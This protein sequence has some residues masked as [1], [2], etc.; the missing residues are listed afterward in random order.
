MVVLGLAYFFAGNL[1]NDRL[2]QNLGNLS[3]KDVPEESGIV[4]NGGWSSGVIVGDVNNDGWLDIYVC[5]ELYDD[6]PSLR[7]NQL[8]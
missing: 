1:E 8:Y 5:R 2:Y 6:Q 3:F 4:D 7:K